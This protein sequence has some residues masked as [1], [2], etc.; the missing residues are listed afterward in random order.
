[1][2]SLLA[3]HENKLRTCSMCGGSKSTAEFSYRDK[4]R[5]QL[6]SRCKTCCSTA[7][8]AYRQANPDKFRE[9]KWYAKPE[10]KA[11]KA[12]YQRRRKREMPERVFHAKRNAYLKSKFGITPERYEEMLAAQN[13]VCAICGSDQPGR[14]STYFHVDHC[15]DT[16]TVRGLLCNGCNLGLGHFKDDISRLE[17]AAK[18]LGDANV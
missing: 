17:K 10:N 7:F 3:I 9:Y 5:G 1:M 4:T 18:Y 13:G 8:K 16:G 15:H 14:N 11:L 2:G 12:E 6:Q